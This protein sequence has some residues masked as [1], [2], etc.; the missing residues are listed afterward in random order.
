[1][2]NIF[3]AEC[4]CGYVSEGL[5]E[6]CG[7]AGPQSCRDLARCDQCKEIVSVP[8]NCVRPRCPKCRHKV[9]VLDIEQA[10]ADERS[11]SRMLMDFECPRCHRST[12]RLTEAGLWD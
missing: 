11:T 4:S 8:A 3:E 6:G 2:G 10:N 5:E 7:M 9:V 1:M 12:M